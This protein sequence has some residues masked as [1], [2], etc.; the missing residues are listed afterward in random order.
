[1]SLLT[2]KQN[3]GS[4]NNSSINWAPEDKWH[5]V[6]I[7]GVAD[8]GEIPNKFQNGKMQAKISVLFAFD[9]YVEGESGAKIQKTKVER[10]TASL[11]EKS[12]LVTKILSPAGHTIESFD[13]LVGLNMRLKLKTEGEYQ[14][15]VN[16]DESE[17]PL[18]ESSELYVPKFWLVDKEGDATGFD[19][20]VDTGVIADLRPVKEEEKDFVAKAPAESVK[21]AEVEEDIYN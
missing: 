5:E 18:G 6:R 21:T 10:F 3:T 1:M 19:M 13:Q 8:I 12:G 11:H 9:E 7:V 4:N 20:I 17:S 2:K 15:I 16:C 14:N